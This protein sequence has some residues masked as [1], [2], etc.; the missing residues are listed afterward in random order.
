VRTHHSSGGL[1]GGQHAEGGSG[2]A[3]DFART[4]RHRDAAREVRRQ[5]GARLARAV[6]YDK[7]GGGLLQQVAYHALTLQGVSE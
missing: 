1:S 6:P 4:G 5:L 2:S 7:G 3:H